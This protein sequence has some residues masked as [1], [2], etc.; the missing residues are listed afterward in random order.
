M[1][2]KEF[3]ELS[4]I[5]RASRIK[6]IDILGG[7]PLLHREIIP[8]LETASNNFDSVFISTNGTD[9]D[10]MLK[11]QKFFPQI[12]MGISL[13]SRP[14]RELR[15]FIIKNRP[16]LKSIGSKEYFIPVWAEDFLK[17]GIPY[18]IIFRD[19][20]HQDELKDSMPFYKF[21]KEM[22]RWSEIYPELR[23]VYCDGFISGAGWRCPAGSTK[24]SI[25]PDGSVFPCYLFFRFPEFRLGNIFDSGL[26]EILRNPIL[27][28]FRKKTQN[29]CD[30]ETCHVKALCHG[31]CPAV[32]YSLYRDL[33]R[34]DP[35]C[36]DVRAH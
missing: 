11:L 27:D 17:R 12:K 23:P 5:L 20:L 34:P 2:L 22:A 16:F 33:T 15:E 25:M 6:E 10:L 32:S 1:G 3:K 9:I 7:E 26:E 18:Y 19:I 30:I 14:E 24:V 36:E 8:V 31:G 28:F 29:N 35:R 4:Q 21:L 13:N